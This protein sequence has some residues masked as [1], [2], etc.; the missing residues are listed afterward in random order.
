MSQ[1]FVLFERRNQQSST[2]FWM[3]EENYSPLYHFDSP[4]KVCSLHLLK[5]FSYVF[6]NTMLLASESVIIGN[7]SHCPLSQPS[8]H[9]ILHK[10]SS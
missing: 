10:L 9:L 3:M 2:D 4:K 5:L 8:V 1:F 6:A 7:R